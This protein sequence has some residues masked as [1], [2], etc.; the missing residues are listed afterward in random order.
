MGSD[1]LSHVFCKY[2]FKKT[3]KNY[4]LKSAS[5]HMSL[6]LGTILILFIYTFVRFIK[7]KCN[8]HFEKYI[9]V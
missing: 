3:N 2:G 5:N 4:V 7:R 9:L 8:M 6:Y 1:C